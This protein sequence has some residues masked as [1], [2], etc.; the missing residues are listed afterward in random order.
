MSNK[1]KL[2]KILRSIKGEQIDYA[3]FDDA[4][5]NLRKQL[6]EK[7]VVPTLDKVNEEFDGFRKKIDFAPLTDAFEKLKTDIDNRENTSKQD[8][9]TQLDTLKQQA[10]DSRGL[11]KDRLAEISDNIVKV[12]E[13]LTAI[14]NKKSQPI[15]DFAKQIADT[16]N[17]LKELID[18][19][20]YDDTEVK[21]TIIELEKSALQLRQDFNN[22]GGG[23]MNRK[24]TFNGVDYLTKYTDIN[25]KAGTNVT[26]TVANNNQTKQVDVTISATGGGGGGG[27]TRSINNTAISLTAGNASTTDYVYICSGTLTITMPT[28]AGNSNLYT[29]KNVGAGIV[30]VS[31]SDTIDGSPTAIMP[32]QYTS[33]DLVSNSAAWVIT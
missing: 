11:N 13:K 3:P 32:I 21:K 18:T 5:A 8:L 24:V 17:R 22:R 2:R 7:I 25:Y 26:F 23:S 12:Q 33:I 4:V 6:E 27:I 28:A 16:E 20:K 10:S 29:I 14:A 19:D 9:Q 1:D 15:P 30:T 31:A